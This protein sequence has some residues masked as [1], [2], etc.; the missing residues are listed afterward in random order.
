MIIR[1]NI[2]LSSPETPSSKQARASA[3]RI[4]SVEVGGESADFPTPSAMFVSVS[5]S[6]FFPSESATI[7]PFQGW[8]RGVR[9]APHRARPG[10][11]SLAVPS[12]LHQKSGRV[13]H[14]GVALLH[15]VARGACHVRQQVGRR[16]GQIAGMPET[17]ASIIPPSVTAKMHGPPFTISSR[18]SGS[19]R[20]LHRSWPSARRG[21]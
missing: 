9:S 3:A 10:S 13:P 17:H 16:G 1:R 8:F 21:R 19:A 12:M 20:G 18:S 7:G 11:G 2:A 6:I 15:D 14:S 4:R 5:T